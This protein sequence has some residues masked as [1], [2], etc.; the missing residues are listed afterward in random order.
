[1]IHYMTPTIRS[2]TPADLDTVVPLMSAFYDYFG[3]PHDLATQQRVVADFLANPHYGTLYLIE[4]EGQPIGYLALTYGFT[5]EFDG[6]D[7]FVDEF[8]V[9]EPYRNRGVGRYA[10]QFIQQQAP[11]LGVNALHLQTEAH[12]GRAKQLYE[13]LGFADKQR[14]TL[15]W[16]PT[17]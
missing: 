10:L 1:M 7:A 4:D 11:A 5:F 13:S 3:Y 17:P 12:N 6:R 15:T 14:S 16:R 2:A 8:F 9:L